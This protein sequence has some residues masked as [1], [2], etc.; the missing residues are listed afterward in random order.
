MA[1]L[2]ACIT[3]PRM[4]RVLLLSVTSLPDAEQSGDDGLMTTADVLRQSMGAAIRER[5]R[6]EG[7]V[8]VSSDPWTE[9]MRV[10]RAHRC[11]SVLLG[12]ASLTDEKVRGR[13]E[14]LASRLPGNA[15]IFRAPSGWHPRSVRNVLVPIGG[16]VV[17][18]ALRA[19]LLNGL[20]RRGDG[21]MTVR[22][23]L[24]LPKSSSEQ[25]RKV[26]EDLW[27]RLVTDETSAK[28]QVSVVLN[29]DIAVAI[30]EAAAE[31]DLVV[32]GLNKP[33]PRRRVF[34]SLTTRVIQDLKCAVMV[35]GQRG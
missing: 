13:L 34:G 32:L 33:D 28:S 2:A 10:A 8:T 9:I 20:R 29:D 31:A 15:V 12:M 25:Q 5:V 23:L 7:L 30:D 1:L 4:G 6:V 3:P 14:N 21:E 26:A 18:N 19:R 11:A 16:R 35:I 17:H 24:V 22:Y 27:S